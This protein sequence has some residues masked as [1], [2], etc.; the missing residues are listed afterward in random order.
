MPTFSIRIDPE[1]CTRCGLCAQDCVSGCIQWQDDAPVAAHPEWCNLCSHC[2][3]ICPA[4][5]VEHDGLSGPETRAIARERIVPEIYREIALTR[6]S[7]RH[8]QPEPPAQEEIV[9]I[10]NLANC[11]PT[12]SNTMDV[13]YTVITDRALIQK[14]SASIFK[15]GL[16]GQAALNKPWGKAL[17]WVLDHANPSAKLGL[18]IERLDMY[19]SWTDAGRDMVLHHAP[20]IIII[21]GPKKGRFVRENCA[22][23]SANIV[24]Y[25]HAKGLG[26]CYIGFLS[27]AMDWNKKL[28][29]RLGVPPGRKPYLALTLGRPAVKY[30]NT[31]V[32][33]EPSIVWKS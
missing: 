16:K 20:A 7:V 11:S 29:A 19:K 13:G 14:T 31:P 9:E 12:A 28:A 21:H 15:A 1:Q 3:A 27:M 25:A 17:F 32:R 5:A 4:G 8:Y 6:R 24:N 30:S 26:T 23:A 33:P 18:Y 2:V 22:I 10:L